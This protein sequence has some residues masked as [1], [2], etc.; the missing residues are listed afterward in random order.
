MVDVYNKVDAIDVEE[1]R[2]LQNADPASALI[3]AR[4]GE[5]VSDLLQM[6][7]NPG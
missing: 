3:S 5:G 1:R 4:T 7:Q 6:N 2:R